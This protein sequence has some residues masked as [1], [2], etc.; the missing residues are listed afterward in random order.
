MG[1][2]EMTLRIHHHL[3]VKD[4]AQAV[5]RIYS[6]AQSLGQCRLWLDQH[7]PGIERI[8]VSSNVAADLYAL[9]IRSA[10]IE[11]RP[12]N[13]TRFLIIGR[14]ETEPS[15]NDKT[16]ILVANRDKPG[17]LYEVLEPFHQ[18]K[19]MD[20]PK[21]RRTLPA[22]AKQDKIYSHNRFPAAHE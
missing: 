14:E 8:A 10:N 11:D 19:E 7:Y 15:A 9:T 2:G 5:N 3:L 20:Q 4:P 13:T 12:D 6:H 18:A 21:Q 22:L 17:A 1:C 16:S